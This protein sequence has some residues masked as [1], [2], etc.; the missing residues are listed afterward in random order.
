VSRLPPW[1]IKE[2]GF[3]TP[4]VFFP[5]G[6]KRLLGD[7]SVLEN[8]FRLFPK[9]FGLSPPGGSLL[10]EKIPVWLN[11]N[12]SRETKGPNPLKRGD[13]ERVFPN[14]PFFQVSP[15]LMPPDIRGKITPPVENSWKKSLPK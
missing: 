2:G 1:V 7:K 15:P 4:R 3:S 11:L 13:P 6:N 9:G 14:K 10:K 5:K 12:L 8:N